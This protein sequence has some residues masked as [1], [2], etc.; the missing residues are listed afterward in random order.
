MY[1]LVSKVITLPKLYRVYMYY[2]RVIIPFTLLVLSVICILLS[3]KCLYACE[4]IVL[5]SQIVNV[6]QTPERAS[7]IR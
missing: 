1:I 3:T 2:G 7:V 5:N 4:I 6:A